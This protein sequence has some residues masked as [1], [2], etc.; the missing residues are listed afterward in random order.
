MPYTKRRRLVRTAVAVALGAT[1]LA[2]CG[3]ESADSE[4]ESGPASLTYWT[5]TPGMDKVVD[6][7][8]K[9]PG[10]KDQITVTVKKQASGDTLVTKILTAH[11]A[12]IGRAHV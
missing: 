4:T 8:N 12:E 1:T 2:A 9:G 10:K 7:W 5:W 11:K 3:T 6:L